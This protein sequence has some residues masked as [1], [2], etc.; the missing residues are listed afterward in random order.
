MPMPHHSMAVCSMMLFFILCGFVV[1]FILH[2]NAARATASNEQSLMLTAENEENLSPLISSN[3]IV[4][5]CLAFKGYYV[6]GSLQLPS[7]DAK[8]HVAIACSP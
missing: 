1:Q 3:E 2:I 7:V 6:A 8:K 4:V 5:P